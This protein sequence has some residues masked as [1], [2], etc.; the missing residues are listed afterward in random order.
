MYSRARIMRP[1]AKR[2]R[3]PS[4]VSFAYA[5]DVHSL[6]VHSLVAL[7]PINTVMSS[8]VI[9]LVKL[10]GSSRARGQMKWKLCK[11]FIELFNS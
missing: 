4:Q 5:C 7:D 8:I 1:P 6:S 9:I 2:E 3:H 11:F 10:S